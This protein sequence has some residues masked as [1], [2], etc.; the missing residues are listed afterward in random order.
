MN[1]VACGVSSGDIFSDVFGAIS[2]YTS[3]GSYTSGSI[4]D[5][6]FGLGYTAASISQA[7]NQ[8]SQAAGAT[9]YMR[10]L[11]EQER[12]YLAQ[13]Y[14]YGQQQSNSGLIAAAV[15]IGFLILASND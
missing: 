12:A 7:L 4:S 10:Q 11:A 14:G 1:R 6:L 13:Q 9:T 2:Q 3:E 15:L 8:V 5:W